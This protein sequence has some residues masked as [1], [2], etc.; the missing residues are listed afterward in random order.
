VCTVIKAGPY[1]VG[2]VQDDGLTQ[3]YFYGYESANLPL[4]E[5]LREDY[6]KR[7]KEILNIKSKSEK[8]KNVGK[9]W[10]QPVFGWIKA[11]T[12]LDCARGGKN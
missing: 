6:M 1:S 10:R 12:R 8:W 2:Y 11:I 5:K 3:V 9:L 7:T 4:P